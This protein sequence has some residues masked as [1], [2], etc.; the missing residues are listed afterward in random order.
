VS[1]ASKVTD[2]ARAIGGDFRNLRTLMGDLS[3]L[4]T[5]S[6]GSLVAAINELNALRSGGRLWT[7]GDMSTPPRIWL[8]DESAMVEASGG[9]SSWADRSGNNMHFLQSA[10]GA[11]PVI[12]P[13]GLNG[14]RTLRF[15][16]V[17][18][19]LLCSTQAANDFFRNTGAG[20]L[21]V[22]YNKRSAE[23]V[24]TNKAIFTAT[25]AAGTA[26]FVVQASSAS[27]A[28]DY[29]ELGIRRLDSDSYKSLPSDAAARQRWAFVYFQQAW[30]TAT[31]TIYMDGS[32]SAEAVGL[33][34]A[35]KTSDTRGAY[36]L[37]L[38][39]F[40]AATVTRF[41]DADIAAVVAGNDAVPTDLDR[42][43]LEGWAAH[44]YGLAASLPLNHPYKYV[45]PVV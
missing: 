25:A 40:S 32:K 31:S 3:M 27:S 22:C 16:G 1:L 12:V 8:D 14:R 43:R 4:T 39:A 7:P 26:R 5:A 33:V 24:A 45:P 44:R 38:G 2:L 20:W 13:G 11:R 19:Y 23:T 37:G 6:K 9:C 41:L 15:D 34:A 28:I 17:D 30:Q 35:G 18:D 10:A 21:M 36:G 42:Q 29:P